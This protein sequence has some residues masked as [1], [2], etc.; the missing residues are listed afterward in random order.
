[1]KKNFNWAK[2]RVSKTY[3]LIL[4][5]SATLWFL[6]RV[7]PKPSRAKYPCMQAAAPIMSSFIIYIIGISA[8]MFSYKKFKQSFQ[9]SR[10][11]VGTAF[12][13]LSIVSFAFIFL[14]DSKETIARAFVTVDETFPV[15]SNDPIGEAKGLFPGRVVWVHDKDATN[16]NF[17]PQEGSGDYWYDNSNTNEQVIK[18]ML[19]T[20]LKE[21]TETDN[22]SDA[23]DA[24]FKSFNNSHGRGDVGYASGEK[25]AFKL[26]L[27]NSAGNPT[28]ER[29]D[30]TPQLVNAILNELINNVGVAA[31]DIT[32][33]DPY[34]DFRDTYVDMVMSQFPD[35]NYVDGNGGNGVTKTV[36]SEDMVLKFSDKDK[37]SSLP[38]YYLDAAYFINIPCL[39]THDVGG[40]TLIAKNHQGSYLEDGMDPQG[41]SAYAMHYSLPGENMGT[42]EFRHTVDYMGHEETGGKGLI[43]IIDGIWGGEN[44]EG[45]IKK[46]KSAPFSNDYP[47][48]IF[49]GQDPV[50]LESVGFDV[51]FEEYATDDDKQNY[52]IYYKEEIADMLS[53]C[54]S[55]DY[56]PAGITYDPEGDGTPI[57]SLGVFEHWNNATDREYSRDLGS[58]DGVELNYY[59]TNGTSNKQ[60]KASELNIASPNPF[61]NYTE[62]RKPANVSAH[63]KLE[64]YNIKGELVN[65]LDFNISDVIKWN[66]TSFGGN[67]IANG[68][69]IYKINDTQTNTILSGKVLLEK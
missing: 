16:E 36:P 47:N 24:I 42:G 65:T 41:Q 12:L 25:I 38:Q 30:A 1:M 7:V 31:S 18:G 21:Y 13:F 5:I 69:Y 43:Y 32:I 9:A 53:Q 55:S 52:P 6:I 26:N 58:G 22:S 20:A 49:I 8:S 2:F 34:R 64:I 11:W 23:W 57:G 4:G 29:M 46:F 61:V 63:S 50:A 60:V 62:F 15:A 19:S 44:W 27:T 51:L 56:W 35:V 39:K 66:G 59:L 67:K 54:A 3:L 40:I 68:M 17:Y 45:W 48:S 10:Y 28:E 33:G 14:N 37:V